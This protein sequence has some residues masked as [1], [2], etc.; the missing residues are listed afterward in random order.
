MWTK[1][2]FCT[3]ANCI[4]VNWKISSFSNSGTCVQVTTEE[5]KILVRNTYEPD[6]IVEFTKEEWDVFVEGVKNGEFDFS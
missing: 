3:D 4:E 6:K 5:G 1:S 2:S